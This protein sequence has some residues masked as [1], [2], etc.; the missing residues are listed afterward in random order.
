[1]ETQ[2]VYVALTISS[3][4]K[5]FRFFQDV[6]GLK[7]VGELADDGIPEPLTFVLNAGVHV[8][9]IPRGGF[10]YVIGKRPVAGPGVTEC[11]LT[12]PVAS[13][14][15]VDATIERARA[16]GAVIIFESAQMPWGYQSVFADPDGHMW[17]VSSA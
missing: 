5:S 8:M 12:V 14:A 16:A 6:L 9:L 7:P 1:M 13:V 4:A 17:A 10:R 2:P 3:R 15:E 11:I